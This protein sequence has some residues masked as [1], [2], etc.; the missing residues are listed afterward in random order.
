MTF[1]LCACANRLTFLSYDTRLWL[2]HK[3]SSL[4]KLY[5]RNSAI[6]ITIISVTDKQLLTY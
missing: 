3:Q 2:T 6:L 5:D 1:L 4:C